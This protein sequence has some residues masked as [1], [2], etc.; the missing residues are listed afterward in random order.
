MRIVSIIIADKY[1]IHKFIFCVTCSLEELV[2]L[3]IQI[4]LVLFVLNGSVISYQTKL[5]S[6][7]T[8][9]LETWAVDTFADSPTSIW[10]SH[11]WDKYDHYEASLSDNVS[12]VIDSS[13]EYILSRYW[14]KFS[15]LRLIRSSM[16]QNV[17]LKCSTSG[18]LS[19]S[20]VPMKWYS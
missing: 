7:V 17:E 15:L 6:N 14:S 11:P 8:M 20:N 1:L 4:T 9:P 12:L 2:M 19:F 13:G 5:Y 16:Y 10:Q 3:Y 18:F